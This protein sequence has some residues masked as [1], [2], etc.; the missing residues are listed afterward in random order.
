[1]PRDLD[2]Q[3]PKDLEAQIE[4][5]S[6]PPP[7]PT[8]ALTSSQFHRTAAKERD[9][10]SRR[11]IK[12]LISPANALAVIPHLPE[13]GEHTHCA[14]KGDF[15]LCDLIPK[16]IERRGTCSDLLIATLGMSAANADTL[17]S[18]V[19]R[20]LVAKL[21][22]ICSH[23][24]REVDKATTFREVC[25]RL[26]G[27]ATLIVTR[28]HAKIIC[29]PTSS[30]DYFVLEGSANLR[31]SDNTEQLTIFNDQALDAF[32]RSWLLSLPK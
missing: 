20:G 27:K 32:H 10:A 1:M 17:G 14:L 2:I 9:K 16:I 30:G 7:E 15:V 22:I 4:R 6:K 11:G 3:V 23:Y 13:P 5:L 24:F 25:A 28:C 8:F 12:K 31:S 19:A 21:S 26:Q 18:L 29:I